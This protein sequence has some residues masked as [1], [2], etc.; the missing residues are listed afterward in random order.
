[1]TKPGGTLYALIAEGYPYVKIGSTTKAPLA[2]LAQLQANSPARL[3]LCASAA[4][5]TN[6]H[7][8][9]RAVHGFLDAQRHDG[10]WFAIAPLD[11]ATFQQLIFDAMQYAQAHPGVRMPRHLGPLSVRSQEV[12][13]CPI[14]A[15]RLLLVR[16][17]RQMSQD[18]LAT[19][20]HLFKTD[21]SKYERGLSMPTLPRFIRLAR[22]LHVSA[23]YLLGLCE[24]ERL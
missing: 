7:A 3:S 19:E 24:Q 9:E 16:K 20:A 8:V 10:E 5:D 23:D 15:E 4:I 11:H 6:V 18:A 2:R 22:V 1:M 14:F 12:S 21:I 13:R 17:A